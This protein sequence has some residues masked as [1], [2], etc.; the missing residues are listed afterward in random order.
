MNKKLLWKLYIG[1]CFLAMILLPLFFDNSFYYNIEKT[2]GTKFVSVISFLL[3]AVLIYLCYTDIKSEK[4]VVRGTRISNSKKHPYLFVVILA[5]KFLLGL[6]LLI[7]S[8][9]NLFL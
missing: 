3:G 4:I 2:L 5:I 7:Y 8:L 9:S 6:F 1:L